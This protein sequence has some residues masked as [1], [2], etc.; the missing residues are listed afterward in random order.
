M[1]YNCKVGST[2]PLRGTGLPGLPGK[3]LQ[4]GMRKRSE[5]GSVLA[6]SGW[7]WRR[8]SPGKAQ[9]FK[10]LGSLE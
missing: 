7:L 3:G 9:L 5:E 6:A 8:H 10:E 1:G 4:S 2:E